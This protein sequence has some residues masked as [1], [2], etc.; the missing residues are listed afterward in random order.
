[1]VRLI[2]G[3]I[4]EVELVLVPEVLVVVVV[5]LVETELPPNWPVPRVPVV[6]PVPG[7]K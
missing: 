6:W 7:V 5:E 1:L 4:A 3:G 2:V